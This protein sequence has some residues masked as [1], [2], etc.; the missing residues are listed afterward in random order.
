VHLIRNLLLGIYT[1]ALCYSNPKFEQGWYPWDDVYLFKQMFW[2]DTDC[3]TSCI[4][5]RWRGWTRLEYF[6]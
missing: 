2:K 4:T 5:S 3:I 6:L 1:A